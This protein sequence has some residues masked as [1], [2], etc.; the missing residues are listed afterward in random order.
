MYD[1]KKRM[2]VRDASVPKRMKIVNQNL[3]RLASPNSVEL[4]YCSRSNISP[5][6]ELPTL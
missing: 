4:R 5:F 6:K 2:F 1:R 3:L